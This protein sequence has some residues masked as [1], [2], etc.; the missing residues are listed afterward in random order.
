MHGLIEKEGG[1]VGGRSKRIEVQSL[2]LATPYLQLS[3]LQYLAKWLSKQILM[4]MSDQ[5]DTI[6]LVLYLRLHLVWTR[7]HMDSTVSTVYM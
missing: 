4:V 7:V 2:C 1:Q 6:L 5:V 3:I